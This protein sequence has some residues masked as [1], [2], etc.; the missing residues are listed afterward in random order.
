MKK[1][2][3]VTTFVAV[4]FAAYRAVACEPEPAVA[5]AT[6]P[7][8]QASPT[9]SGVN[10]SVP[11]T[12]SIATQDSTRGPATA[13]APNILSSNRREPTAASVPVVLSSNNRGPAVTSVPIVLSSSNRGPAVA[14]MPIVLSSNNRGPAVTSVP[15]VLSS[16]NQRPAVASVPIVLSS[17]N[18]ELAGDGFA[19]KRTFRDAAILADAGP[20]IFRISNMSAIDEAKPSPMPAPFCSKAAWP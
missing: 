16:S 5:S 8:P 6:D 9:C 19:S 17:N 2:A 3:F 10:C 20:M 13:S 11:T 4:A 12:K 18:R 15:I 1:V 14:S 7:A